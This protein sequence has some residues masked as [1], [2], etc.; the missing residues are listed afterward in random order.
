VPEPD[1]ALPS[2]LEDPPG[3]ALVASY[4]PRST[5]GFDGE[6][7]EFYG[8][9][10]RWRRLALGDLDLPRDGW[11]GNDTYGAGAL[12]PDGRWWAG[13]MYGGMFLV[14]LR[15]GSA[16]VRPGL[17]PDGLASFTWSPDSDELVLLL[18]GRNT[19]VSV[20][21]LRTE[22]FP[23]PGKAYPFTHVHHRILVDGGWV[24]CPSRRQRLV[25]CHTH[26]RDGAL[27]DERPVPEDLRRKWGGPWWSASADSPTGAEETVF[28]SFP[29]GPY[30]NAY[31]DWEVLR[32]D[33]DFRADARLVLP[34]GSDIN[35]VVDAL[36]RDALA[37]AAHGPR[38]HLAWLV[39]AEAIVKVLRPG[40]GAGGIGQDFWDVS[41]ARDL[42]E[43][44]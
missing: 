28:Y 8:L 35:D 36:D 21:T 10:G 37:L 30:G 34:A 26:G 32:T 16:S 39:D 2:L 14:D 13:P 1:D 22:T 12:S 43:V 4:V 5:T 3:R 31:H 20:P 23:R 33:V 40:V 18:H 38:F 44:R 19:R 29:E 25:E 42:A 24:E 15:D 6:A 17:G 41:Y 27:I 7:V 11:S 9:D